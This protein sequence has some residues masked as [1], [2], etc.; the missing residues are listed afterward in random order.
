[1]VALFH[2]MIHKE[3]EVYVDDMV[4]KSMEGES[5]MAILR[6]LFKRLRFT[7]ISS[8]ADPNSKKSWEELTA[9]FCL[10][11][12]LYN[13]L[14]FESFGTCKELGENYIEF[15]DQYLEFL[16]SS[17]LPNTIVDNS[18]ILDSM[19]DRL[20]GNEHEIPARRRIR[21]MVAPTDTFRPSGL[22]LNLQEQNEYEIKPSLI[23]ALPKFHGL[24]GK[25]P[26]RHLQILERVCSTMKP[27]TANLENLMLKVFYFTLEDKAITWFNTL[28]TRTINSWVEMRNCFLEKYFPATKYSQLRKQ[29]MGIQQQP[30]ESLYEYWM[31]FLELLAKC[32]YLNVGKEF[33]IDYF[34]VG[35]QIHDRETIDAAANG[36]LLDLPPDDAWTLL[37]K[38]A[39]NN[40]Q[41]SSRDA[42]GVH[43]VGQSS[44]ANS[45]LEDIYSQ[46]GFL[47]MSISNPP[48]VQI[49]SMSNALVAPICGIC[50]S[51]MHITS[52][53]MHAQDVGAVYQQQRPYN[54]QHNQG[55]RNNFE[56]NYGST[57]NPSWRQHPNFSYKGNQEVVQ[58]KNSQVIPIQDGGGDKQMAESKMNMMLKR[59]DNLESKQQST[60]LVVQ[61]F[62]N[63]N[64]ISQA[65]GSG[66]LP[67]QPVINPK[68]LSAIELRSG[69]VLEAIPS[70]SNH[71]GNKP[72]EV[73]SRN[74]QICEGRPLSLADPHDSTCCDSKL[75]MHPSASH[76]LK[77]MPPTSL[78]PQVIDDEDDSIEKIVVEDENGERSAL[79]AQEKEAIENDSSKPKEKEVLG[80]REPPKEYQI[81][82][83]IPRDMPFPK[84]LTRFA[85]KGQEEDKHDVFDMLKKVEVNIPLLEMI[86]SMPKCAKFLKELCTNKRGFKPLVTVQMSPNISVVFKPQLPLKYR[87]PGACTIPCQIGNVFVQEALIGLGAAINMMPTHIYSS[88]NLGGL[89]DCSVILQLADRSTRKPKGFLEDILVKVKDLIF[90]ADF[91]VLDMQEGGQGTLILGRPFMMT[92]S[93]ILNM[94]EGKLTMEFLDS[95]I[96][97]N[98]FDSLKNSYVD[99]SLHFVDCIDD[100]LDGIIDEISMHPSLDDELHL[101]IHS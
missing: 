37:E 34:H 29:I 43:Q 64:S 75:N 25:D 28:A 31:R 56:A 32:P 54:Y 94:K 82:D 84:A 98:I 19:A 86:K 47:K 10:K 4:A 1:M 97:F 33:L 26:N 46:L 30:Q 59:L 6:K 22:F 70:A 77:N 101:F 92:S 7:G 39:N 68:S 20:H 23:N 35:L 24:V 96:E 3:V 8:A 14:C 45:Q 72:N 53:C 67:T 58:A 27:P 95:K 41:Y 93:T 49:A 88:L 76:S 87:D 12:G 89:Q 55:A 21:E 2:D 36:S 73:I 78:S 74:S 71:S 38:L 100:T 57:Y 85:K 48:Q 11:I 5:H 18:V 81:G 61:Q 16:A 44:I 65:Q 51:T 40:Q 66:K 79:N 9:N 69:R 62:R 83:P 42:R 52:N 90:S 50:N 91:Y 63:S 17:S 99:Y 80:R 15:R 60:D 13:L